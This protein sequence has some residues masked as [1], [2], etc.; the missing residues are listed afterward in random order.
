MTMNDYER[1][2]IAIDK[3]LHRQL[4]EAKPYGHTLQE[5]TESLLMEALDDHH[6]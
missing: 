4:Y 3:Q 1:V 2:T 5:F 6:R